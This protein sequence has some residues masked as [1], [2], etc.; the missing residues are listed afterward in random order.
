M[1][2]VYT[3]PDMEL[4]METMHELSD[5]INIEVADPDILFFNGGILWQDADNTCDYKIVSW[6]TYRL[7]QYNEKV[8]DMLYRMHWVISPVQWH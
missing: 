5:G 8:R 3:L 1:L 7:C 6:D 4:V 2:T